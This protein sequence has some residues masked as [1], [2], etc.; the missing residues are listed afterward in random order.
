[1]ATKDGREVTVTG[2]A[3]VQRQPAEIRF[4][5]VKPNQRARH[6]QLL[7]IAMQ[8]HARL[9]LEHVCQMERRQSE[10][11]GDLGDAVRRVQARGETP[12][13]GQG[14]RGVSLGGVARARGLQSVRPLE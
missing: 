9:P 13:R 10:L 4:A 6:P 14:D 2:E 8:R 11:A 3:E 1:M 5:V 7:Q 12:L